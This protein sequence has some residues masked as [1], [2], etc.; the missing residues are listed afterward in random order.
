MTLTQLSQL[1]SLCKD[2]RLD[3]SYCLLHPGSGSIL[4]FDAEAEGKDLKD[5]HHEHFRLVCLALKDGDVGLRVAGCVHD[6]GSVLKA[7]FQ[8]E[9]LSDGSVMVVDLMGGEEDDDDDE[10]EDEDGEIEFMS[11][12]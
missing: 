12:S 7:G 4:I 8:L 11:A 5:A 2:P 10:D 3:E 6:V 1:P 9:E